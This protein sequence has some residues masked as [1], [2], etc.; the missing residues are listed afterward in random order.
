MRSPPG[1]F[2]KLA[3]TQFINGDELVFD[4]SKPMGLSVHEDVIDGFAMADRAAD[5]PVAQASTIDKGHG[6]R[7]HRPCA[8]IGDPEVLA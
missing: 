1:L 4:F 6:R 7:E 8:V 5:P 3:G 2:Q